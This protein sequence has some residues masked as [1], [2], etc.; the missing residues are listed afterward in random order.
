MDQL[1]SKQKRTKPLIRPYIILSDLEGEQ[2][3]VA[4]NKNKI[5]IGRLN[6]LNDISLS[7]DPQQLVTRYMHCSIEIKNCI[8]WIID[9]AS[10]NGTFI[11][12]NETRQ[13]VVGELKLQ[14]NDVIMILGCIET[15]KPARYWELLYKDPMST[16]EVN[17]Y[18]PKLIYDWVQAKLLVKKEERHV[19]IASLTP[20]EHKLLRFMDQKNKANNHIPVMCT[21]DELIFALWDDVYPHTMNDVTHVVAGLRKKIEVDY[22][23]PA[24]LVNIRGMGYKLVINPS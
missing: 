17:E 9:N 4:I 21:Y 14:D 11:K 2:V 15:D 18:S 23:N 1:S 12:R 5:I 13:R 7:P 6:D 22:K 19:E 8:P 16:Q 3:K 20:L 10:K 24:F